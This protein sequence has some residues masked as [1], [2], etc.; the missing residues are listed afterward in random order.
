M[1]INFV[2]EFAINSCPEREKK[3]LTRSCRTNRAKIT[4]FYL[5]CSFKCFSIFIC[6]TIFKLY[7][8]FYLFKSVVYWFAVWRR[9]QLVLFES[10]VHQILCNYYVF[11]ILG[12]Y[13]DLL[14]SF[15]FE[16]LSPFSSPKK[17]RRQRKL[18]R[19]IIRIVLLEYRKN[20]SW[21]LATDEY[22]FEKK[23]HLLK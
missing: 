12:I 5:F 9:S 11:T 19:H 6:R 16:L 23:V 15:A 20:I 18:T 4:R 7:L 13:G 2:N 10:E 3:N 8:S 17:Q 22:H 1:L 21:Y 14:D